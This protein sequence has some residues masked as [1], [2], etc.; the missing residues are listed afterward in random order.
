MY[1]M[2]ITKIWFKTTC[3]LH[4]GD[5]KNLYDFRNRHLHQGL[6]PRITTVCRSIFVYRI[7]LR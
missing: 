7:T 6:R 3:E 4:R 1:Y 5:E 2:I